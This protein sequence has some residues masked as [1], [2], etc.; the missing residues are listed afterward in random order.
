MGFYCYVNVFVICLSAQSSVTDPSC[1]YLYRAKEKGVKMP[2]YH[3]VDHC[4]RIVDHDKDHTKVKLHEY[5]VAHSGLPDN[6]K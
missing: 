3:F 5:A 2:G 1:V 4:I 6:A